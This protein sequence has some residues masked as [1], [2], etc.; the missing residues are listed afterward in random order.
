MKVLASDY[1]G[2]FYTDMEQTA[3]NIE[4]VKRWRAAGN[5]F[6]IVT[7]RAL[8]IIRQPVEELE[9]PC[10]F[11]ICAS[12]AVICSRDGQLLSAHP[13]DRGAAE[14]IMGEPAVRTA[15]QYTYMSSECCTCLK[16][17]YEWENRKKY[18]IKRITV[19]EGEALDPLYQMS[20]R[21]LSEAE[22]A[23]CAEA[24]NSRLG[25]MVRAHLNVDCVDITAAGIDKSAGIREY[26][27][28]CSVDTNGI[29]V[30]GDGANDLPMIREFSGFAVENACEAVKMAASRIYGSVEELI[31]EQLKFIVG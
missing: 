26:G 7:G 16:D 10:D 2:T 23:A 28:L 15:I 22:A 4:A 31:D 27:S 29:L 30:I 1:D 19:K 11:L 9:I 3:R 18:R 25:H 14:K 17:G 6:G 12:G 13:M 5:R 24:V 8:E 21:H 20:T